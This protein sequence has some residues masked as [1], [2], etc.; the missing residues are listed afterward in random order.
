[1]ST[2]QGIIY[3]A[4]N[5]LEEI[6]TPGEW[7]LDRAQGVL[8]FWPPSDL[9]H[10]TVEF[11]L[12]AQPML[13]LDQVAHVRV[14]GLVFDL[15]RYNCMTI[16][17]SADCLVAACTVRRFAGNGITIEG[18]RRCGV[19]GCDISTLGRRAI[20]LIGG[21]RKT[22][23]PG[24]HFVENCQIH[25]MGR[26]DRTYTPA[27]QLE[28]VGN[29]VAHN[30]MYDAPSSVMR[31]EGN[32]HVVE[33]NEVHSAVR[34]S[35]DQG[36]IDVFLN[37]TYRGVIYRFNCFH[38]NGK[39]GREGAVHGQAGIRFDDAISGMLVYGNIFYRSANGNFGGVQFNSGR[40]NIV[41]NNIFAEC[42]QAISGGWYG[43]NEGWKM[44]REGRAPENFYYQDPLYLERYPAMA[45]M[46]EAPGINHVWRNVFY[47]CGRVLT[48]TPEYFEMLENGV[49]EDDPG[50]VNAEGGDFAL[51]PD[52]A[53]YETVGFRPIPVQEIGLYDDAYRAS[54]P[55]HT[56]VAAL[57]NWR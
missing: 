6:D 7:Y 53:L 8:Y 34:E 46:L 30:L 2:E 57:L 51:K 27:I 3:Y 48:R 20:E 18:G 42:K 28:G 45:H 1:M 29:R 4:F 17:D 35:D 25:D 49:F 19:L 11:G 24:G 37:P 5:L 56:V 13:T 55:V 40:D 52:A 43:N 10:A 26:I 15:G 31:I 16:T 32:D 38:H 14:E 50:F 22:L 23:T 21:D 12:L 44:I 39:T 33:Y 41:D 36:S 54:W 47:R 9:N